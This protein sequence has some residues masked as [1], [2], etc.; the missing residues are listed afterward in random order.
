MREYR[1][2]GLNIAGE[3]VRGTVYAPSMRKALRR[4]EDL[5][6]KH[7]FQTRET[8]ERRAYLYKVRDE[9]GTVVRGTQWAYKEAE[10]RAALERVG[11]EVLSV[12]KRLLNIQ[13][14]PSSTDLVL[15][16]RLAANMLRRRLPF[17]EVLTLLIADTN[18]AAL[19]QSLRDLNSD[20][21]G[22][23]DASH[24]FLK[25]QHVLGK[26]T[27][28]MLGLAATSGNMAEMFEATALYLERRDKFKKAIRSAMITPAITA[29]AAVAAFVWYVWEIVPSYARMF[30]SYDID[31]PPLTT[32][33]LLFADWMDANG[34]W[35][36]LL[37]LGLG[38]GFVAWARTTRGRFWLHQ[39]MLK[40]PVLGPLL[41]K[42][43]LEVFSRV[44][45]VLYT[46]SGEGEEVMKVAAEATGNTYIEHQVKT[47]TVPLMMAAG[48]D[49]IVS[50]ER[51]K[52]F[53]PM[54][55]ARFRSGSETGAVRDAADEMADFYQREVDLKFEALV[56]TI[57]TAVAIF[58]SVLV[59]LL[60]I[61]SAESAFI[62]PTSSD[63][64]FQGRE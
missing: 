25:Q 50:M 4:V 36:G 45:A 42:M 52:V 37:C 27:A 60:T 38:V 9:E 47:V 39:H 3:P 24:A 44:F 5:A 17:A 10:V 23:M 58:I 61:V 22:G 7:D 53:T 34:W 55:L 59:L 26:F 15:F 20:L 32:A 48:A 6:A 29:L 56:E 18:S 16:V 14:P 21:K 57:K 63:I 41:Q 43:N 11:L 46:G 33:S 1:F 12:E 13:L 19:K 40:I 30:Q 28:Y 49:L 51:A 8:E 54:L 31:L 35:V 2:T 64:M 62:S